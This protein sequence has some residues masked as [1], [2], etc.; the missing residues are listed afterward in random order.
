MNKHNNTTTK[1]KMN[2]H[3]NTNTK[4]KMNKHNN[5]NTAGWLKTRTH[6]AASF[7]ISSPIASFLQRAAA[8]EMP[9]LHK[10][11]E[12]TRW[13]LHLMTSTPNASHAIRT[14]PPRS[15]VQHDT[16][17]YLMPRQIN[18]TSYFNKGFYRI[19]IRKNQKNKRTKNKKKEYCRKK[20]PARV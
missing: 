13:Q 4:V 5:T 8:P 2:K 19:G 3:N 15:I 9:R 18:G 6:Y 20:V 12:L 11:A 16:V 17:F 7:F 14:F 10:T 1:F